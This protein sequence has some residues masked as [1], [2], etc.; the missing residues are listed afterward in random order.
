MKMSYAEVQPN[1]PA[2]AR[3]GRA[4]EMGRSAGCIAIECTNEEYHSDNGTL[5]CSLMKKLLRSPAHYQASLVAER[6][7]T[8]S[9]RIGSAIHCAWLEPARFADEYTVYDDRRGTKAYKTFEEANPGKI[10]LNSKEM[11]AVD[12]ASRALEHFQAFP[13]GQFRA[14]GQAEKSIY[15]TDDVTGLTI[16]SRPDLMH[17]SL[18][19]DLKST[20]DARPY[21]FKKQ[22]RR[23][24][25][26]L[27]AYICLQAVKRLTG[28][29]LPF[30]FVAVEIDEPHGVWIHNVVSEE[31]IESGLL[32]FRRACDTYAR[33]IAK[34]VWSSYDMPVS[35]L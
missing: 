23:L 10:I 29:V 17:P 24:D 19:L 7:E 8:P 13:L 27:Q 18:T 21:A 1:I 35:E 16:R 34:G 11:R 32:K 31:I 22:V 30:A 5:S 20:D 2:F 12:G 14:E 9:Q 28:K 4:I 25:Y 33:A 15:F 6:T 26:D 3:D